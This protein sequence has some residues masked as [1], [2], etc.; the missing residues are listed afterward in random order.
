LSVPTLIVDGARD[1]RPRT[2]VDSLA[3]A[4][5]HATRVT[6]ADAGH[7]PWTESPS[8][9]LGAVRDFLRG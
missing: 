2:S 5:P 8:E 6:L 1:P 7:L 3:E 4:L 9:F